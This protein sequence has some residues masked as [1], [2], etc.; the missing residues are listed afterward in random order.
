MKLKDTIENPYKAF[1]GKGNNSNLLRMIL[2]KR[3]W[4]QVVDKNICEVH[5]IW[6]QLKVNELYP[7]QK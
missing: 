6:T 5:L 3:F 7:L 2:K 1:V 4:W